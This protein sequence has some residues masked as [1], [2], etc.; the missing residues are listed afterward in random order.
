METGED[1]FEG[2]GSVEDL[3]GLNSFLRRSTTVGRRESFELM[4]DRVATNDGE[5]T[6]SGWWTI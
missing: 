4:L 5:D 3:V 6:R 2:R 1:D